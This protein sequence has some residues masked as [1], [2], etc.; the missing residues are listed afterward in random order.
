M[1]PKKTGFIVGA[2]AG[3]G[4]A[5]AALAGVGLREASADN[6][7]PK[8]V[9]TAGPAI[10]AP[11]P[12]APLSFA[13]IFDRVSPAVVSI[14][15]TSKIERAAHG[16][17]GVP[18]FPFGIDPRRG[19]RG[20]PGGGGGDDDDG[21]D[22][23]PSGGGDDSNSAM[24]SGSGFFISA[25][26]YIVTNN[27][28]VEN[29]TDIKVVLKD[30]RELPAKVV[31]RDEGTDLAVIK[32]E[33]GNFPYV[34]F[35]NSARPRVGDWVIA[36]GN[37]FGLGGT[38]TAG[39]I[40]AYGRNIGETF[41]D[42]IQ[43]DAPINRGNS[44]GPTF[45][46]YGRVIGVNTAIF[47]PSGGS[48][49]IGFAIPADVADSITKQL[50]S[51]GKITRGYLGATIQ[52]VTPEIADSV[53]IPGK[54]GALVAE[55]VPGGPAEKAGVMPGDVVLSVNGH[56]VKDSTDLT[57]QV[58]ASH[59]GDT[60]SLV[61]MRAGSEKTINVKSG[62]RP[63]EADLARSQGQD[64]NA[65]GPAP[66][67]PPAARP[68]AL[69]LALGPLDEASRRRYGL[70]ADVRGAVVENVAIGSDAAKKGL[71]RGDVVVRAGDHTITSPQDAVAA[72]DA[73]RKAGRPSV[74]V[75]IYRDGR[76]LG[77]PIKI[78]DGKDSK[79]GK[80]GKGAK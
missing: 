62:V 79:D 49:G 69:G 78:E 33:G 14:N 20:A 15:V 61:V 10:F 48:V 40:S 64:P 52:A 37:P 70:S 80:P 71:K 25:D 51:G 26:G 13:D 12:G 63:S 31:G 54:K 72:I 58:A 60:L 11:P 22:G 46:I 34:N 9:Q 21:S 39:I 18:N 68:N 43:I 8:L 47:S 41:V 1:A 50:I 3:A 17:P 5:A 55:L 4:V 36:V 7:R 45:D 44:G 57:R 66:E 2:L 29:S 38:A 19:G 53:G 6:A 77:V 28:V 59:T 32:V 16:V 74:L 27:H 75:F 24:A 76:Q 56:P 42:Y 35:E 65:T 73:A 23:P 30:E 67:V